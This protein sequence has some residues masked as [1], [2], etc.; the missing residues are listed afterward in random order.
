MNIQFS[1]FD[2]LVIIGMVTGMVC[3]IL[4]FSKSDKK[5]S[6]K[7]LGLGILGF[8]WLNTKALLL[9]LDLWKIHGLGFFPNG[10]ELALPPLFY[11]YLK[12]LLQSDF[13]FTKKDWL[14]FLPFCSSQCYAIVV[15][16]AI[17]Q[18]PLL[19]EK[20]LIAHSFYF[21]TVKLSEEYLTIISE[22]IYL[23]LAYKLYQHYKHW[24]VTNTSDTQFSELRFLKVVVIWLLFIA[25]YVVMNLILNPFQNDFASWRWELSHL[26]IAGLVYYM[27]MVG[28]KNSDVIPPDF[29]L[30][31]NSPTKKITETIIDASIIAKL[32]QAIKMDKVHLNP[33]LSLQELAK[34]LAVNEGN[35]SNTINAYYKK[36]FRSVINEA[37]VEEVK[38]RL[39][40]EGISHLSLLGVAKECGFNSEAS[41]YRIFKTKTGLTP[42]QFLAKHTT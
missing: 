42:K 17:M 5:P 39:R 41:F 28:F 4:L 27:G 8:V 36:N 7:F 23:Y 1:V 33:K 3:S 20:E 37:R 30:K 15:Y 10:I 22:I 29:S 2:L 34:M 25:I 19:Q 12:S 40:Q 16:I 35:L 9:S 14:H 18:T 6:N 31:S 38:Q 32:H 21:D 24:L 26:L 11:F 13:K